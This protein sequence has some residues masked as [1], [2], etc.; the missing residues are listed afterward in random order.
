[1]GNHMQNIKNNLKILFTT[2]SGHDTLRLAG[3]R[4]GRN[5]LLDCLGSL[6]LGI[7]IYTF[8]Y[9]ADFAPGGITGVSKMID[10]VL[11]ALGIISDK[12]VI[13][14]SLAMLLNIPIIAISYRFLGRNYLL[15]TFQTLLINALFIDYLVPLFPY[16][17]G[18][19]LVAAIF[20]GGLSGLGYAI[21]YNAGTCTGGSDLVIM[22]TR[23]IKPHLSIGQITMLI[24]GSIILIGIFVYKS[25]D[26]MLYGIIYTICSTVVID[27]MMYGFVSG[28]IALIISENSQQIAARILNEIKRGVTRIKGEGMYTKNEKNILMCACS[29][30]QL[31]SIRKIIK[32]TDDSALLI[33][34]ESN[35]V[36][37]SGFLSHHD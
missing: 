21:I 8:S 37:G 28:K 31:P 9:G 1:M 17:T 30:S 35:E 26:A 7:G 24:D 12:T 25:V 2:K 32:E 11:R 5:L 19:T 33:V 6:I 4:F 15:R 27:K 29:K 22:T 16:Y 13:I 14:G 20:S 10:Y 23:K 18:N 34:L 3:K 36:H